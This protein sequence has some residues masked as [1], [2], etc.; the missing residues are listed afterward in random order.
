ML[1]LE[2][3]GPQHQEG[4]TAGRM[5]AAGR[6]WGRTPGAGLGGGARQDGTLGMDDSSVT[7]ATEGQRGT[8]AATHS[9]EC[10]G[11]STP[12]DTVFHIFFHKYFKLCG[13]FGLC[14]DYS[15]LLEQD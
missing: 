15:A 10:T 7:E 11:L 13:P 3:F 14:Q 4:E 2:A 9:M 5:Q 1:F 6:G 8:Q 12:E